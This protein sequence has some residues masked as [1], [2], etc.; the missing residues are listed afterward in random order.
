MDKDGLVSGGVTPVQI[1]FLLKEQNKS[2]N[3]LLSVDLDKT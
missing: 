2:A 3:K 1:M